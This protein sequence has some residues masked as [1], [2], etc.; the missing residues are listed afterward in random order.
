MP[1]KT[2]M[3]QIEEVQ[4]AITN[5][6][7]GQEVSIRGKVF[8]MAD[9]SALGKREEQLLARY[10]AETGSGGLAINHGVPRRAY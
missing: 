9:L 1:I 6:M 5:V 8:R 3:E 2:T 10:R 4:T 7:A